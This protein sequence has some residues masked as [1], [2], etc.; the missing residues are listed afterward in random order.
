MIQMFRIFRKSLNTTTVPAFH[1]RRR[2]LLTGC[3]QV[4]YFCLLLWFLRLANRPEFADTTIEYDVAG[5]A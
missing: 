2:V 3:E 5:T 4:V 1:P